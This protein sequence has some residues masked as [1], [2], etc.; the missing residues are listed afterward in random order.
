MVITHKI[1][2]DLVRR[3]ITPRIEVVQDDRYSRNLNIR[4]F[5]NGTAFLPPEDCHALIHYSKPDRTGGAYD[6]MPDGTEAW[7]MEGN[8]LTIGLAP[9][10]CTA[11]GTVRLM[12]SLLCGDAE[13]STFAMELEVQARVS[14]AGKS[15]EYVSVRRFVPQPQSAKAGEYLRVKEV[16]GQGGIQAVETAVPEGVTDAHINSLIDAKLGVIENGTY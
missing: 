16:D 3:G 8:E 5:E 12:V 11:P 15:Q 9:Q 14:F 1:N 13:L 6:T 4:L 10:V 7:K 2:M